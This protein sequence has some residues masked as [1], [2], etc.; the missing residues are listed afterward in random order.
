LKRIDEGSVNW[1]DSATEGK[2][3]RQCFDTMIIN[4]N[5]S[6]AI[7]FGR[8]FGWSTIDSEVKA[9]GL[10]GITMHA[11]QKS[12]NSTDEARFLQMIAAG[13]ILSEGS[14]SILV[15][16]MSKQVYRR[17]IPAGANNARVADKV[18]FLWALLHDAAIVYGPNSNYVI[19]ILTDKSSWG[20]IASISRQVNDLM[21]R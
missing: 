3:I 14:R 17:G 8:T 7:W 16:A 1:G 11:S 19:V 2:T 6:C 4:S 12:V 9:I 15:D 10:N 13:Q 5:N 21:Q 20:E 18:G